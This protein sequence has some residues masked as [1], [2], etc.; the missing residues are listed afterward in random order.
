MHSIKSD[1][2]F[3]SKLRLLYCCVSLSALV[4]IH[5]G[6]QANIF[7]C[8]SRRL[9]FLRVYNLSLVSLNGLPHILPIWYFHSCE[10]WRIVI[11][12]IIHSSLMSSILV[13]YNRIAVCNILFRFRNIHILLLMFFRRRHFY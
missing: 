6:L 5:V 1:T 4:C 13:D 7:F 12:N 11:T 9:F 8:A 3:K 2:G 10:L